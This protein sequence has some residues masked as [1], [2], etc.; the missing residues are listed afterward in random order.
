[1]LIGFRLGI[2]KFISTPTIHTIAPIYLTSKGTEV[3]G[4]KRGKERVSTG[5]KSKNNA[6][7]T[8]ILRAKPGYAVGGIKLQS[9][10]EIEGISLTFMRIAGDKLDP[11]D[12]YESKW[13]G[14]LGGDRPKLLGGTGHLV[15]G[16]RGVEDKKDIKQLGFVYAGKD[17]PT[18]AEKTDG[19]RKGKVGK[20]KG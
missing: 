18:N 4:V 8:E 10:L 1:V 16:L 14:S 7:D 2:G 17:A 20:E 13:I 6:R 5:R 19:F 9:G 11:N 3:Y 12:Q 15:I